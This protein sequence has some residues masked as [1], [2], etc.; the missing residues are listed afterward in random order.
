LDSTIALIRSN[1]NPL[2]PSNDTLFLLDRPAPI[3]YP[4]F[5]NPPLILAH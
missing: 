2:K 5:I 1:T 4:Q 3:F